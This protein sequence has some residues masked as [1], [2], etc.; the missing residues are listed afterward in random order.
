MNA[1]VAEHI[2]FPRFDPR[3]LPRAPP[4]KGMNAKLSKNTNKIV[5]LTDLEVSGSEAQVMG[6][7][8]AQRHQ[9]TLA[10][11]ERILAKMIADAKAR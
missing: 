10:E 4:H 5:A 6:G 1:S 8:A 9:V 7:Q 11:Y 3:A 2:D